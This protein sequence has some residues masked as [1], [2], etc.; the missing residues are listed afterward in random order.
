MIGGPVFENL[1]PDAS[2]TPK[3]LDPD[4]KAELEASGTGWAFRQYV[5]SRAT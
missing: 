4:V 3:V 2:G 1:L 5:D